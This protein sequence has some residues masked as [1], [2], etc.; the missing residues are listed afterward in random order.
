MTF[1]KKKFVT[2]NVSYNDLMTYKK[3]K[4]VYTQVM[5]IYKGAASGPT[6]QP[7]RN[8]LNILASLPD[9]GP[10]I[11]PAA[12]LDKSQSITHCAMRVDGQVGAMATDAHMWCLADGELLTLAEMAKLMGHDITTMNLEGISDTKFRHMLGMSLH[13]GVAGFLC[14][15]LIAGL[16]V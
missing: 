15:G 3:S 10:G 8:M 12:V 2:A 7:E 1:I 16:G 5:A 4:L 6:S 11:N 9:V 13:K 14:V